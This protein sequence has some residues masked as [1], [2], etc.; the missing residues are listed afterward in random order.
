M[1]TRKMSIGLAISALELTQ[2]AKLDLLKPI[3]MHQIKFFSNK[4]INQ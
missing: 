1:L 4:V 3:C 2:S